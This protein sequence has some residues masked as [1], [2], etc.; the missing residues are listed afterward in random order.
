LIHLKLRLNEYILSQ[1]TTGISGAGHRVRWM[2]CW[3]VLNSCQAIRFNWS[4]GYVTIVVPTDGDEGAVGRL[5]F[6]L[7]QRV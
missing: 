4:Y 7:G 6:R 5:L 2:P 1:P 3:G